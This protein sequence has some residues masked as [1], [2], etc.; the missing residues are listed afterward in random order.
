LAG[1]AAP[2]A[3]GAWLG[4][5]AK[6]AARWWELIADETVEV[7]V[8]GR[9]LYT[10]GDLPERATPA[11]V[12]LLPAYD[13][14]LEVA[15]REVIAPSKDVRRQVWRAANNPGV[16]LVGGEIVG[17]WRRKNATIAVTALLPVAADAA[18][19]PPPGTTIA[20]V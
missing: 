1:A 20:M 17:T 3:L 6:A 12:H 5:D 16:L 11:K 19:T 9:R 13:P 18:I 10:L 8:D 14:W 4:F 2:G 7:T 15:D